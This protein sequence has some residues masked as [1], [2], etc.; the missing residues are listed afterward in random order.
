MAFQWGK[1]MINQWSWGSFSDKPW[2]THYIY[3]CIYIYV[4]IEQTWKPENPI[5]I[6]IE[7]TCQADCVH[8]RAVH[9]VVSPW[10]PGA[11]K[12]VPSLHC[13]APPST[14]TKELDGAESSPS[15]NVGGKWNSGG[16]FHWNLM[17]QRF[18][19]HYPIITHNLFAISNLNIPIR[20]IQSIK[21]PFGWFW[22]WRIL[23]ANWFQGSKIWNGDLGSGLHL[24]YRTP[25]D[26]VPWSE[27]WT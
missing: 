4:W 3:I 11:R 7:H 6:F 2:Q 18:K 27:T 5:S 19:H 24:K 26:T 1:N 8:M 22:K 21:Q 10:N 20:R 16:F 25:H 13:L 12:N 9:V 23:N 15:R 14:S 17:S